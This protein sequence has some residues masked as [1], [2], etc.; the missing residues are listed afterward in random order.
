MSFLNKYLLFISIYLVPSFLCLVID[1]HKLIP[2]INNDTNIINT[3][4][5]VIPLVLFN[6]L[7]VSPLPIYII[8]TN[9]NWMDRS[10][11]YVWLLPEFCVLYLLSDF[12]FYVTHRILHLPSFYKFHKLHHQIIH[13]I[14]ISAIYA[15]PIEYIFG[16]ILPVGLPLLLLSSHQIVAYAWTIA[17]IFETVCVAHGGYLDMSEY[18]DIHH[19]LN[20]YNYGTSTIWDNMF[21]TIKLK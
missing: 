17:S 10:F 3:Y 6:L 11:S 4:K 12:L 19:R 16:N 20:I 1:T 8:E 14:G 21:N 18:H 9:L 13:P 15:H 5:R 7:I 2:K